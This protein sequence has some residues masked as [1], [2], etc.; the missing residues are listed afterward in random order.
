MTDR[1]HTTADVRS[2]QDPPRHGRRIVRHYPK[3]TVCVSPS[4]S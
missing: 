1:G 4:S 2:T 3:D